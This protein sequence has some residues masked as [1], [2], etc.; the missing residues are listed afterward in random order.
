MIKILI[1]NISKHIFN[2][3]QLKK[4]FIKSD[5]YSYILSCDGIFKLHNDNIYKLQI[6]DS[7]Y[8]KKIINNVDLI[9]DKS[10][11]LKKDT[12]HIPVTSYDLV[13]INVNIYGLRDKANLKLYIEKRFNRIYDVY[14]IAN[15]KL[16]EYNLYDDI[17]TF[18]T[19]LN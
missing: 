4:Y 16:D 15:D 3:E 6:T 18:L 7:H 13:D 11:I 19:M 2:E 8:E 9:L 1:C 14:F 12:Y 10:Y 5:H 17:N